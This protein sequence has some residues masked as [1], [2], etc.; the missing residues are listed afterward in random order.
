MADWKDDIEKYKRGELSPAEMHALEK[1]ALTD[2]FLAD[3]LD[4]IEGL[5][6]Q[7]F[8]RDVHDLNARLIKQKASTRWI[9]LRIAAGIIVLLGV[10]FIM[11][12]VSN[13]TQKEKTANEAQPSEVHPL[14]GAAGA[15]KDSIKK[16]EGLLTLNQAHEEEK[17]DR[18]AVM[19]PSP[20]V[21]QPLSLSEKKKEE[22]HEEIASA[23]KKSEVEE[24]SPEAEKEILT[25]DQKDEPK[26]IV[27]DLSPAFY[28]DSVAKKEITYEDKTRSRGLRKSVAGANIPKSNVVTR[29][30]RGQVTSSDDG[31][32]LPGVNIVVKGT[33]EGTITD[34]NGNYSIA[35]P[36]Q[37]KDQLVFSFIGLK[38]TEVPINDQSLIN[39]PM[40]VDA[41]QLSEVVVT[42]YGV[43]SGDTDAPS[44]HSYTFAEPR[45]GK[46]AFRKYLET[47][48]R[49][50]PEAVEKKIEGRVIIEFTVKTSGDLTDFKVVK[51]IGYGCDEEVIRLIREGPLWTPSEED[52]K[53]IESQMRVD[54]KF[55]LPSK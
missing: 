25:Q 42:G 20:V 18:S 3:A 6:S 44:T 10:S 30:V 31:S 15:M 37:K 9:P 45:G 2:P 23:E 36:D 1:K 33:T 13:E 11:Y 26:M 8:S 50:P 12:F 24:A 21:S 52:E 47:N 7:D 22:M 19:H 46:K 39:V 40:N 29:V 28:A 54:L 34:A 4:G 14:A 51:G 17:Q 49:Y 55:K 38:S 43:N 27:Q 53:A 48:Q 41:T 32:P 35:V 5:S 16:D